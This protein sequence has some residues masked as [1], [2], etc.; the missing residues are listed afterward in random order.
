MPDYDIVIIG[1]GPAGLTAGIYASRARLKT[2]LLEKMAPGGQILTSPLLENYPGF[3]EGVTGFGVIEEMVKQAG[4]FG[5]EIKTGEALK[6]E[7]NGGRKAISSDT[8][9][10]SASAVIFAMGASYSKLAV[11][12]EEKLSGRGVSYC[13]TCD[14]PLYKN[15]EVAV[16]GGGD[17]AIEEALHL[18]KFCSKVYVIHRRDELRATKI[19]QERAFAEK[20]I[21]VVWDAVVTEI[22]GT[23]KVEGVMTKGVKTFEQK[24][25]PVSG[26]FLAVGFT[27][28][29]GIAKGLVATDDKGYIITDEDMAASRAG[30]FAAGDCRRKLL[31][32]FV[33]ACGD[34]ATAAFAAQKYVENRKS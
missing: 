5:L 6:I 17:T 29:T 24:I 30:F 26:V 8:G 28:H 4:R 13:A 16:V 10:Y 1:G 27:P 7:E 34:G 32:Q 14:G 9:E 31:R 11:P 3:S 12:G 20:K 23:S 2:L 21:T 15:K 25:V 22:L 33:T 18:A 19:L